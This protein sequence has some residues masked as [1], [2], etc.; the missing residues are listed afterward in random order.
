MTFASRALE[1]MDKEWP[2]WLVL[3]G[4]LGLGFVGMFVCR[5]CPIAALVFLPLLFVGGL[6]QVLELNAPCVGEAIRA[7]AGLRYVVLSYFAM[8]S[9]L[10]LIAGGTL[11]GL[12]RRKLVAKSFHEAGE[13]QAFSFICS[14]FFLSSSFFLPF[15]VSTEKFRARIA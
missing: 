13:C 11:Q 7:E 15:P 5:R 3:V 4:F 1:V 6:G 9:T 2:L 8:G 14:L 12:A 10:V